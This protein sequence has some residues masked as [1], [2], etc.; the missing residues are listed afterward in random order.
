MTWM[1]LLGVMAAAGSSA[2]AQSA[3]RAAIRTEVQVALEEYVEAF[4]QGRAGFIA[5][6]VYTAP[7]YFLGGASV[8]VRMTPVEVEDR[9]Q[10]MIDP[11]VAAGYD[12]SDIRSSD[13]CVL[14]DSSALIRLGFARIHS[15]GSVMLEGAAMYLYIRTAEGWRIIASIGSAARFGDCT[16]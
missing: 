8:D 7:A 13:V 6:S 15:D 3:D 9:F 16:D 5:D 12:R 10:A 4:S 11:L 14:S 1:I 2:S